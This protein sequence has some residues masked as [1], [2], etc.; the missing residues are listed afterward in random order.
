DGVSRAMRDF[1]R[2]RLP[3]VPRMADFAV[4]AAAGVQAWG[5]TAQEFLNAYRANRAALSEQLT[6]RDLLATAIVNLMD[7]R[8]V[9]EGTASDLLS[10]LAET[11]GDGEKAY[12]PKPNKLR[13]RL[14]EIAPLLRPHGIRYTYRRSGSS[15]RVHRLE[16]CP[17]QPSLPSQ[18]SLD[19]D[20]EL[21]SEAQAVTIQ[22][23]DR[24]VSSLGI[25]T[26]GGANLNST[27]PPSDDSDG[28]DD[29]LRSFT[30]HPLAEW[31][32]AHQQA[33]YQHL[34]RQGFVIEGDSEQARQNR[35][36][37]LLQAAADAGY[38]ALVI[39]G[40]RTGEGA[41][42]WRLHART[43]AAHPLE[44][45][46]CLELFA[47]AKEPSRRRCILCGGRFG[48]ATTLIC[49]T[50][51]RRAGKCPYCQSHSTQVFDTETAL[52]HQCR[53]RFP[54]S[55][56]ERASLS[57][58]HAHTLAQGMGSPASDGGVG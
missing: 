40:R 4:W 26:Q 21:N 10:A 37:L 56:A 17:T 18:P 47:R 23:D 11:V 36:R 7:G 15:G 3:E 9:W 27:A 31:R 2:L 5:Y 55:D 8:E 53:R 39:S 43:L 12:L 22:G 44:A 13:N 41:A 35:E 30:D 38:P 33:I 50:C 46:L 45:A 51:Q 34:R 28:S 42:Y 14:L 24:M 52:C 16:K 58:W 29:T 20:S 48:S 6:E 49:G 54:L 32:A 1:Q 57:G 25:V 19:A